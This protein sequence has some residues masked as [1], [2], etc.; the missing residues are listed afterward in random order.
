[1]EKKKTGSD[2][3]D[4]FDYLANAASAGDCTGLI[5]AGEVPEEALRD[6]QEIYRFG[7][8]NFEKRK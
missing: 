2:T 8:P 4:S 5:P 1:M 6:Y 7:G 3:S